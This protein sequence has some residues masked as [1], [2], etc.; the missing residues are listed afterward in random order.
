MNFSQQQRSGFSLPGGTF[1][2][3]SGEAL[4]PRPPSSRAEVG[5]N[6]GILPSDEGWQK[7]E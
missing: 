7:E 1:S 4:L 3:Y 6:H 5:M 2:T